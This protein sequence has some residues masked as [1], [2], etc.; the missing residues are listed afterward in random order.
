M[1]SVTSALGPFGAAL[2]PVLGVVGGLIGSIFGGKKAQTG[3]ATITSAGVGMPSG[4]NGDYNSEAKA[5]A[6]GVFT[7]LTSLVKQ[8]GG[9]GTGDFGTITVGKYADRYRVNDHGTDIGGKI[10][11][12][13]ADF[14]SAAEAMA[15]A[16]QKA[17]SRGAV[18]GLDAAVQRAL[19]SS[20]DINAGLQEALGVKSLEYAVQGV[21]GSIQQIF[22]TEQSS[23]RERLRLAKAYG[24]DIVATEKL[25]LDSMNKLVASTLKGEVGSLQSFVTSMTSGS[26]FEGSA[27]NKIAAINLQVAKAQ[28]D[29]AAGVEGAAETL[30]TL[31]QDRVAAAKDAYGTTGAYAA[32]RTDAINIA[33]TT[34]ATRNA[35][36][37]AA[38]Q[39]SDPALATTNSTLDEISD[40]N[41]Q[42]IAALKGID[43][44]LAGTVAVG[45]TGTSFK[46]AEMASR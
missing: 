36:I 39:K 33:N 45:S 31:L 17:V 42:I 8:L 22:D 4:N 29:V 34:I 13:A 9:T 3:S 35:A 26:L 12:N 21:A 16:L 46:L 24:V 32:D 5:S 20:P 27:K 30:T 2:S 6:N 40:Q 1:K 23:A 43:G 14:A 19:Q 25:N 44:R 41:A 38:Q 28:A 37:T 10:N 15:F 11:L 18:Q 7:S